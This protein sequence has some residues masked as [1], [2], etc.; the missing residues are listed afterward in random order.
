MKSSARVF[1]VLASQT[2][3]VFCILAPLSAALTLSVPTVRANLDIVPTFDSTIT[4]D[5]NAATIEAGIYATI[6][7]VESDISNNTTVN[8]TFQ[9]STTGLGGS[10]TLAYTVPYSTYVNALETKQTLS[11]SDVSAIGSLGFVAGTTVNNPVNGSS[12]VMVGTAL[13]RTLGIANYNGSDGT[14]SLNT[15]I[16]NLSRT[17]TQNAGFYDLQAV[18]GHEIDEV[19]GIGGPGSALYLSGSYTGQA[20]PTGAVGVLD[21]YRYS[22]LNIRSFTMDPSKTAYFSING[23]AT[24]LVS[25]NQNGAYGA[26]FADWGNGGTGTG[27]D[28]G[29]NPAQLQDAYGAPGTMVNIGANELTALDVIGYNLTVAPEPSTWA[30]MLGGLGILVGVPYLRRARR[31]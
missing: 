17:G 31:A 18:A 21:L 30:M 6:A 8:I 20:S 28:S 24:R 15:S 22:S 11:A 12:S 27:D 7:R 3:R 26:D 1:P 23:G 25:F 13:A 2:I 14:I 4:S 29:N 16:M 10:S 5:P 9:E 19:L